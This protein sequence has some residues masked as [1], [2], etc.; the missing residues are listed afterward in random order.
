MLYV[1]DF[2]MNER[3]AVVG[4]ACKDEMGFEKGRGI[5]RIQ[6]EL[7]E[8]GVDRQIIEDVLADLETVL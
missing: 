1:E 8:K 5:G 3:I 7:A 4:L 6:R 2:A